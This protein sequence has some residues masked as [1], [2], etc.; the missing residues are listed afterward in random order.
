MRM[1]NDNDGTRNITSKTVDRGQGGL[2]LLLLLLFIL[3]LVQISSANPHPWWGHNEAN[4]DASL[5]PVAWS[6]AFV[7]DTVR[8]PRISRNHHT[9][10]EQ[11]PLPELQLGQRRRQFP[12]FQGGRHQRPQRP[13]NPKRS[14]RKYLRRHRKLLLQTRC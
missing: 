12:L 9:A 11:A 10:P 13:R 7:E 2:C 8:R 6:R 5:D 14:N 1:H 4:Y 3:H